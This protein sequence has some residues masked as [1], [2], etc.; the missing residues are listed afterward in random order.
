LEPV[1]GLIGSE[2]IQQFGSVGHGLDVR[3]IDLFEF[4]HVAQDLGELLLKP[5]G[6][7]LAE[8]QAGQLGGVS[9]VKIGAHGEG[10]LKEPLRRDSILIRGLAGG[11]RLRVG[12]VWKNSILFP[13]W[14]RV[15]Y[16]V[17][18]RSKTAP[19]R[20]GS[21]HGAAPNSD[22]REPGSA[23]APPTPDAA[24]S[25]GLPLGTA[26]GTQGEGEG[27]GV[28]GAQRGL[29]GAQRV[30]APERGGAGQEVGADGKDSQGE[31]G[32]AVFGDR[33]LRWG[34]VFVLAGLPVAGVALSWAGRE[35]FVSMTTA[36][37]LGLVLWVLNQ[38]RIPRE[39]HGLFLLFSVAGW[40][41]FSVPVGVKL[42]LGSSEWFRLLVEFS[43]TQS[44][45]ERGVR[46]GVD[47]L[48]AVEAQSARPG[49]SALL[50]RA[51]KSAG[52]SSK[53]AIPVD[54]PAASSAGSAPSNSSKPTAG[55]AS[56]A[57][58]AVLP[59]SASAGNAQG[60][61]GS[62][63]GVAPVPAPQGNS[64]LGKS[65]GPVSQNAAVESAAS[66]AD[67]RP[68][69]D[70]VQRATRLA[71]EEAVRRYPA[72]S[73]AGSAEHASYLEAY[74]ELARLRKFE[75]FKDPQWP[76]RI[77]DLVAAREGWKRATDRESGAVSGPS[78]SDRSERGE[79][80]GQAGG[81][82]ALIPG[83]GG[84]SAAPVQAQQLSQGQAKV[85]ASGFTKGVGGAGPLEEPVL[86]GPASGVPADPVAQAT[87]RAIIEVRRRYPALGV[88][89]SPENRVYLEAY[90]E[91]ERLRPD[92]FEKPEWPIHLAE[93]VAKR[94]GWRRQEGGAATAGT[95]AG[96]LEPPL[97]R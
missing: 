14:N 51:E 6:L 59:V 79:I 22:S 72:L 31:A 28:G 10:E 58:S 12:F 11:R 87:N 36:A 53:P 68:E 18:K 23:E 71:Q 85:A 54:P 33:T 56:E 82:P 57:A 60:P 95:P 94:E 81:A 55:A 38:T 49:G 69:E 41:V 47:S 13:G 29:E 37:L 27:A 50:E 90:R 25:E 39:R 4:L 40:L 34:V 67:L 74:N 16:R 46:G 17:V 52:A 26:V 93:I 21:A 61:L 5:E 77:A 66:Q 15:F 35:T 3:D 76:L 1:P 89:G 96:S 62:Q 19:S 7:G 97:P 88:D 20:E 43:R 44:E 65:L 24:S 8:A 84:A 48:G 63:T 78:P 73:V 92:F 75:F 9:D 42:F 64:A 80:A 83:A 91:L 30:L 86:D 70:P 32:V 2:D 45:K